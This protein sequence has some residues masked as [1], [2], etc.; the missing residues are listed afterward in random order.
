MN[1]KKIIREEMD[2]LKW[3][4]D[5]NPNEFESSSDLKEGDKIK[6]HN[7]GDEE[8]FI[9]WLASYGEKYKKGLYGENITGKITG[10]IKNDRY[11]GDL[12]VK[13]ENTGDVIYFPHRTNPNIEII[14]RA[15]PNLKIYYELIT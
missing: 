10:I 11:F 4:M 8:S 9:K 1:L 12:G 3:I 7:Y 14:K 13:E 5:A 15:Y 2:D 6:I